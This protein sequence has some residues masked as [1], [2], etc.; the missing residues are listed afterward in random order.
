MLL[1]DGQGA[2]VGIGTRITVT[3]V[4]GSQRLTVVGSATSITQTARRG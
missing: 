3:G 1:T 4:P 2:G